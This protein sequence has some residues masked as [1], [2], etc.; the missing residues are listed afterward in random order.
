MADRTPF[1]E[2][3]EAHGVD[4]D[5]ARGEDRACI[6]CKR[7]ATHHAGVVDAVRADVHERAA[8]HTGAPADVGGPEEAEAEG[9][10]YDLEVADSTLGEELLQARDGRVEA[11]HEGF[12][13]FQA[14]GI[15]GGDDLAH[16]AGV[17]GEGF[18]AQD[19]LAL[20][21]GFDGPLFVEAVGQGDVDGV[22]SVGGQEVVVGAE[23]VGDVALGCPVLRHGEVA[24]GDGG[25]HAIVG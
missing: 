24:A 19:V 5:T 20:M 1:G 11:I 25:E 6:Y 4:V 8:C 7:L 15:G 3:E 12:H 21:K 16:F 23:R 18:L 10:A 9:G 22:D 13:R 2:L 17:G 14:G